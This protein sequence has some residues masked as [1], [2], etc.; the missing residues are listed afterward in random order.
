[1]L[2]HG[3][4]RLFGPSVIDYP[5]I[6]Y[7]Y[8]SYGSVSHL[9]GRGFSLYGLLPDC[10]VDR[11]NI[12]NRIHAREFDL[13]IYGSIHRDQSFFHSV[14]HLYPR[15]QVIFI[16][17]ED[18]PHGL[19]GL[20]EHG[21]YFQRELSSPY[22]GV[23]PIHFA[24]PSEKISPLSAVPKIKV[25]ATLDPRDRSTYIYEDE[26]SYYRDYASSLFAITMKKGGW[27][28]LRHLEIMAN[29][30]IP[31]F[32]DLNEC[33]SFTCTH[34]P[35]PELLEALQYQDRPSQFW[36]SEEGH[37]RWLSLHHH[38]KTHFVRHCTTEALARYV[39]DTQQKEA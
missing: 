13:I 19:Y 22:P 26:S 23:H 27:D 2:F 1:M 10:P 31:W 3:L 30:C 34:L 21:L 28:C 12:T 37:A 9:Y 5:R 4:R 11:T 7:L 6:D 20:T 24:I 17:G 35:K 33:P 15:H 29:N 25:K 32:L 14:I 36:D 8:Q 16:D 38:I 18:Q 39:I